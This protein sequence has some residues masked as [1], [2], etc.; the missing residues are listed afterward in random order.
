M[1]LSSSKVGQ[2]SALAL[3]NEAVSL[4]RQGFFLAAKKMFTHSLSLLEQ[5]HLAVLDPPQDGVFSFADDTS[6]ADL[7]RKMHELTRH[8]RQKNAE[9]ILPIEVRVLEDGDI[10][11]LRNAVQY[12][13]SSSVFFPVILRDRDDQ[14]M[15]P[16][17]DTL[18]QQHAMVLYNRALACLM[19]SMQHEQDH[20]HNLFRKTKRGAPPPPREVKRQ[21]C[22]LLRAARKSLDL[23]SSILCSESAQATRQQTDLPERRIE[24]L[25]VSGLVMNLFAVVLRE[26]GQADRA[27]TI[28]NAVENM[29]HMVDQDTDEADAMMMDQDAEIHAIFVAD[30]QSAAAA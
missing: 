7:R 24:L 12:G 15:E 11:A 14:G 22:K 8:R 16:D 1:V 29:S 30:V 17:S 27:Q 26:C 23:A 5:V 20:P 6:P 3:N 4:M 9:D 19:A 18:S 2:R 10:P 28:L 13:M 21:P 25:V